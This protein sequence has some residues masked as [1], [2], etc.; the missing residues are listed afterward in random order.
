MESFEKRAKSPDTA[1]AAVMSDSSDGAAPLRVVADGAL[2]NALKLLGA[3]FTRQ[4]GARVECTF[5]S[6]TNLKNTL[7]GGWFDVIIGA[8]S[9]PCGA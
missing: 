3:E 4:G 6:P 9:G 2:Q 8:A 5:T 7:T 1:K